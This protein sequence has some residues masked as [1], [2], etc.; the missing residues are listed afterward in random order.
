[1]PGAC[2]ARVCVMGRRSTR[3]TH[4]AFDASCTCA[5]AASLAYSC[6]TCD[7]D[8]RAVTRV[9]LTASPSQR[10]CSGGERHF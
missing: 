9:R 5:C 3:G 2:D 10:G 1:M 7:T 6:H 4:A 8:A